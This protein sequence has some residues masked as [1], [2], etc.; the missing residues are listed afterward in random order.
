MEID[1]KT[2]VVKEGKEEKSVKKVSKPEI[3]FEKS[4]EAKPKPVE[5]PVKKPIKQEKPAPKKDQPIKMFEKWSMDGVRVSDPGLKGYI[6][7]KPVVVPR[8][9]G[10][11]GK[12]Q[13]YKSKISLVERLMNHLFVNGHRGK[14]H[15]LTSGHRSGKTSAIWKATKEALTI[16]EKKTGK[17]PLQVLVVAIENAALREE[18]TSFQ[19]GGIMARK[20]VIASPQRRIDLALRLIAQTVSKKTHSNPKSLG[21]CLSDELLACY[22]NDGSKSRVI[23]DKERIEREA[24]GAR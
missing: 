22:N 13:F 20:A 21:E 23:K 15:L 16:M 18:V 19:V 10:R 14:K 4:A 2:G 9:G 1:M 5:Q 12:K 8:S 24:A 3:K 17:N 6:S 7:L 11:H